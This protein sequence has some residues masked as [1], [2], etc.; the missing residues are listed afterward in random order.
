M[1]DDDYPN[2]KGCGLMTILVM[3][4]IIAIIVIT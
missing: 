2:P 4:A 1:I 3:I